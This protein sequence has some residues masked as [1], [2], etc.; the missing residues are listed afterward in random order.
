MERAEIPPEPKRR[1]FI[2]KSCAVLIGALTGLVPA[3]SSLLVFLDPLRRK[4]EAAIGFALQ[5]RQIK[6]QRLELR[7]G[8]R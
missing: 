4:T 5:A 3:I 2:K 8:R 7:R 6:K 1:D